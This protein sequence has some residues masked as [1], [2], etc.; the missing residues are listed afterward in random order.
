ME[1]ASIAG[2]RRALLTH[3]SQ[4]L[5]PVASLPQV[6][7]SGEDL[8]NITKIEVNWFSPGTASLE[9]QQWSCLIPDCTQEM[10][11]WEDR[12]RNGQSWWP[13]AARCPPPAPHP[14]LVGLF[15]KHL[16][17]L[18]NT[19]QQDEDQI[20]AVKF[21]IEIQ[22]FW[23]PGLLGMVPKMGELKGAPEIGRAQRL[24]STGRGGPWGGGPGCCS[25]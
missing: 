11:K 21:M 10:D 7:H 25:D 15:L 13:R 12:R 24:Q 6:P 8:S 9:K 4:Q 23:L 14:L 16:F 2:R 3:W 1:K 18:P 19:L 20:E 22:R 17:S 5:A